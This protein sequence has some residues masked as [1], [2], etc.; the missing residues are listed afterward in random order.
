MM[1]RFLVKNEIR[2]LIFISL[3]LLM[4]AGCE[5]FSGERNIALLRAVYQSGAANFNNTGQLATDGIFTI[6]DRQDNQILDS[7]WVSPSGREEWIYV[8][9]GTPSRINGVR[10]YWADRSWPDVYDIQLSDNAKDWET[11]FTQ[12]KGGGGQETCPVKH[13]KARYVRLFCRS[14]TGKA[15]HLVEMEVYGSNNRNYKLKPTPRALENGKQY[16]REGNWRLQRASQTGVQD[17]RVLS[18]PGWDDKNWLPAKVPGTVL[19]SW[20]EAGAIPDPNYGNQQTFISDSYFTSDFWYRNHFTIPVSKKGKTVRLNFDAINW[21]ADIYFNGASLGCINGAFIRGSFDI[22]NL[23]NYG[24]ENYLAV[25]IH[26]NDNPGPVTMQTMESPGGNGGILG[27]DNPTIH[28]S[29]G[30]DWVPTIRG[31]NIGIYNDV[32]IS[33]TQEIQITDPWIITDLDVE[34]KDFSKA[35][36]TVKTELHNSSNEIREII[37]KGVIQPG[38]RTFE[39]EPF[40]LKGKETREV[41]AAKLILENPRLW[42]PNTYG[43]PFLYTAELT[44]YTGGKLSDQKNFE[45]G[46]RE[47]TYKTDRPLTVYCN[48]SRIVCR[49]GNWGMDDSNLAAQEEDYDI[50]VRLHAEANLTMIRNWVGMTGNEAFYR[51]CDK[52]G[53][54][55]WDDFWLANPGDGPNPNDEALFI[56]NARDKIKRN[57][58][59]AAL[60]LYCGRNEG[61]PPATLNEAL[62]NCTKE[63]DGIRHYIPHSAGGSVSGF[64]PYSAQDTEFYYGNTGTTLHSERGMPNIPALESLER[65]LPPEHRWP[66]DAV[67]GI[68]DFTMGGAQGGRAF[69]DKMNRYD[70]ADDL[71]SFARIAQMVNYETHK[72]LFEAVYTNGSN[73]MLMWMSQSAWPSMVW[74]TYDYYYDTNGG[75]FGIKK[76]NQPLNVIYNP[77]TKEIVLCNSTAE[78]KKDLDVI[79]NVFDRDGKLLKSR[80][81]TQ[82][83]AADK[84]LV[85][86]NS[87]TDGLSGLLFIKTQ[88]KNNRGETIAD[89]FTW[90]NLS[91]KYNYSDLSRLPEA[92]LAAACQAGEKPDG[93]ACYMITV[94]NTGA[95]PAL[96]IRIKTVDEKTKELILPVYYEDNY[97]SLMPGE[98]KTVGIKFSRKYL[99]GYRP[100]FYL[101][102]WNKKTQKIEM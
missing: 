61:N 6:T 66:V 14:G 4:E 68:H 7:R 22:T 18:L 11:V 13:G 8:D 47:F 25:L 51:A 23:V 98:S 58:H 80:S 3:F 38:N 45:F 12:T 99:K 95:S 48:G 52:Y 72:A 75:Y 34:N 59:H 63:L 9:L 93:E 16:L 27:A 81:V 54:L 65:M 42:W 78:N 97:F 62:A 86:S 82:S 91:K 76:A 37:V 64:G 41:T 96:M 40:L 87:L 102:G 100:V 77:L 70:K 17:G 84:R 21:K 15:F 29:V 101:E 73:G 56:Q 71:P 33:Y 79:L 28:A 36:L 53:I 60:A 26:K 20:L 69:I 31:R 83:I 1:I 90:V 43:E 50:K 67:W 88:I 24:T 92:N 49:G 85:I 89:N 39:S 94:K 19:T 2:P 35:E 57:R 32:F 55:I 5:M 46:V 74:Q 44:A 30:W 10:L